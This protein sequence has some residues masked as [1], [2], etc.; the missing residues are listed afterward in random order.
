MLFPDDIEWILRAKLLRAF[1]HTVH[2]IEI[3]I[4]YHTVKA[5]K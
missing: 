1:L 5:S 2:N 3:D 4:I